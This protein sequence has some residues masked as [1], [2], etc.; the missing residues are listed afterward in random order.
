MTMWVRAVALVCGTVGDGGVC[1]Y[2]V[3]KV[4]I[5]WAVVGGRRG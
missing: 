2:V 5:R 4:G 3:E 1:R